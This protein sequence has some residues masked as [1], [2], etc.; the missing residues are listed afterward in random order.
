MNKFTDNDYWG[1]VFEDID[2][3]NIQ[4]S[5]IE[6]DDCVFK[7]CVFH[8][9]TFQY[10]KFSECKFDNCDLSLMKVMNSTFNDVSIENSKAIG[11]NW[12]QT[13]DPFELHFLSSNISMSSFYGKSFKNGKIISCVAHD[14]DFGKA[15]LEKINFKDTNLQGALFGNTNFKDADL[16]KATQYSINPLENNLNGTEISLNEATSF[17]SF[18]NLKI[19]D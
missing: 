5:S 9:T 1:E 8:T 10:C 18:F 19:V 3:S 4:I 11:I 2:M 6:F 14:T 7:N 15:N 17:L 12:E 16:S 13:N